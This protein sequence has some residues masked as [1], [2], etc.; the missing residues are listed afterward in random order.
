MASLS[1]INVELYTAAGQLVESVSSDLSGTTSTR[2]TPLGRIL[3]PDAERSRIVDQAF[4]EIECAACDVRNGTAVTVAGADVAGIDFSLAAGGV[5]SGL[6]TD[7]TGFA[8]G[9]ATVSVFRSTGELSATG[10]TDAIGQDPHGSRGLLPCPYRA[11]RHARRRGLR[12]AA[13]HERSLRRRC[14]DVNCGDGGN[15]DPQHQLHCAE[16]RRADA[17]TDIARDRRRHSDL[18]AGSVGERRHR[19]DGVSCHRRRLAARHDIGR[20]AAA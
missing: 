16:L 8:V 18:P 6:V 20:G 13:V 9:G 11:Q 12:R 2:R 14:R 1:T 7:S 3:P 17:I 19:R 15:D 5:I 10:V 4:S